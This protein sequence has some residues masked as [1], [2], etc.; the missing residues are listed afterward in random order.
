MRWKDRAL[1]AEEALRALRNDPL[2]G[3]GTISFSKDNWELKET[4][5]SY[6]MIL[7]EVVK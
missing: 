1:R 6:F 2:K 5:G 7:K 3:M 4:V